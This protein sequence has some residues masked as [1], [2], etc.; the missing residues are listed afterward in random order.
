MRLLEAPDYKSRYCGKRLFSEYLL[1]RTLADH[2]R[3]H[4]P[5]EVIRDTVDYIIEERP[6]DRTQRIEYM[7]AL[8]VAI[9]QNHPVL[10]IRNILNPGYKRGSVIRR[11]CSLFENALAATA[12]LGITPLFQA[13]MENGVQDA[14][15]YFGSPLNCA[16]RQGDLEMTRML[17]EKG[18]VVTDRNTTPLGQ[19]LDSAA[20]NGHGAI[21]QLLLQQKCEKDILDEHYRTA[22]SGAAAGGHLDIIHLLTQSA[23]H[24]GIQLNNMRFLILRSVTTPRHQLQDAILLVA[25]VHGHKEVVQAALDNGANPNTLA[26]PVLNCCTPLDAAVK[27][28]HEEVVRLLLARGANQRAHRM[29]RPLIHAARN[30]WLRIAQIL[31]DDGAEVNPVGKGI[32]ETPLIA[33]VKRG[34]ADMVQ[35]LL[36]NGAELNAD[37]AIG[38]EA[39]SYAALHRDTTTMRI[40]IEYGFEADNPPYR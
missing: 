32:H 40:L 12:Y 16:I 7:R 11:Q 25:A 21:V 22:F 19:A 30:G 26:H 18:F 15:T 39:Y 35:L 5:C 4:H 28:G 24:A 17:L 27:Y 13:L 29:A 3:V 20:R 9:A 6:Q 23:A 33:A 14:L 37:P 38:Q 31:I 34:R 8:C 10:D 36:E 1:A 2:A